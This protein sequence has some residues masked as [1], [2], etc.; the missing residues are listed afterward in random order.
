VNDASPHPGDCVRV[1]RGPLK[2]ATGTVLSV[3]H[4]TDVALPHDEALVSFD[5]G[6]ADYFNVGHLE[7]ADKSNTGI[8]KKGSNK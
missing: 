3:A 6:S 7:P 1:R 8:D 4:M 2:G 5:D